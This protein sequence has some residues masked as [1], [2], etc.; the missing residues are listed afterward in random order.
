MFPKELEKQIE[1]ENA[2]RERL[3]K[4]F[5]GLGKKMYQDPEVRKRIFGHLPELTVINGIKNYHIYFEPESFVEIGLI[6]ATPSAWA[7]SIGHK[8]KEGR[9][10]SLGGCVVQGLFPIQGAILDWLPTYFPAFVIGVV[11]AD[12]I[13]HNKKDELIYTTMTSRNDIE[14]S[15]LLSTSLDEILSYQGIRIPCEYIPTIH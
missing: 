4:H 7:N 13:L 12:S 11:K 9:L 15:P 5:Y 10:Y 8:Q 6:N 14:V 3:R 1:A 2:E